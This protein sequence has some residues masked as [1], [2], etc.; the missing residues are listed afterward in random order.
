MMAP[1]MPPQDLQELVANQRREQLEKF[2]A[3]FFIG[4]TAERVLQ[5]VECSVLTVKP[6]RFITPVR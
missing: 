2:I 5:Q 4:N 1:S 6:D 3:P